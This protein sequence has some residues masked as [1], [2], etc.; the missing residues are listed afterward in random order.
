[1]DCSNMPPS[2]E[3][4]SSSSS[5]VVP[6]S[7]LS[8]CFGRRAGSASQLRHFFRLFFYRCRTD[9]SACSSSPIV[10]P[11]SAITSITPSSSSIVDPLPHIIH[12][13]SAIWPKSIHLFGCKVPRWVPN[14]DAIHNRAPRTRTAVGYRSSSVVVASASSSTIVSSSSS[15][16]PSS[17]LDC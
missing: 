8:L 11:S 14:I 16:S 1:M 2:T 3:T 6:R 17:G 7:S 10:I 12:N 4:T 9:I 15:G 13:A 5:S